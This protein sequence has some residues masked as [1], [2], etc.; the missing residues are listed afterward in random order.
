MKTLLSGNEAIARGAYENGVALASAYPGTPSTEILENIAQYKEIVS[1]WAPNEKVALDVAVGGAYAGARS[2]AVMKH[3][4]LNVAADAFFYA[5]MTGAEAGLL[6]VCADDPA[7]HSSQNEQ[8]NRRYCKFARLPCLEPSDSQEAK[9][10]VGVALEISE[11]FDTP[12]M[13]RTTT[14]LAHS[15]TLVELGERKAGERGAPYDYRLDRAKYVMVPGNARRRHPLIE[16]RVI[17]LAEFA[18]SFAYNTLEMGDPGLGIVTNGVAYQYAKEVFPGASI[19]RLGMTYPLPPGLVRDFA[20]RV[21]RLIVIEELDPFIEEEIRLM[22]IAVEGKS[23][24][25]LVGE[26]DPGVVRAAAARVGLLEAGEIIAPLELENMPPLPMRPPLLCPG[27]PHRGVFVVTNKLKLVVNGDIGCYTLGFLPP[28]SALHTCGCMGASIGV[29]HGASKVGI[30]QKNVAV[31]GDSTFFHSG[32]PALLNTAYNRSDT[33]TVILDNRTTAMTGH[34]ENPATGK[35]LAGEPAL[36]VDFEELAH[37]LGIEHTYR[38]DPYDLKQTETAMR[39]ALAADGPAVVIA[40]RACALLPEARKDW[41]ALEVDAQRCN[42]CGLCFKIGCPAILL[43]D[44]TDAKTGRRLAQI[45][46]LLCTGCNICAQVC[47]R[48]AILN[49]EEL[50]SRREAQA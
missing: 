35:N 42:G 1:E 37:A 11:R 9:D 22:G 10:M 17:K 6:I 2:M 44:E 48:G 47:A 15:H 41:V 18:E 39:A 38:V 30:R 23:I 40:E 26:L 21:E 16:A 24:F 46:A 50:L 27:C 3:V 8:D 13:L 14:R 7:M 28:L 20:G 43:S 25:P 29:A 12:V 5:S 4:G 33:V 49:R 19:L 31:L 34:Q 45:D 36:R 32:M